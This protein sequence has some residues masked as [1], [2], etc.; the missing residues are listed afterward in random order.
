VFT[1]VEKKVSIAVV[2]VLLLILVAGCGPSPE[3][4]S[5][6][7]ATGKEAGVSDA[8]PRDHRETGATDETAE[9]LAALF[10][11]LDEQFY[12]MLFQPD[13]IEG[14]EE[15]RNYNKKEELLLAVSG[16]VCREFAAP[17]VDEY[18]EEI[19]NKLYII[20]QGAP[21]PLLPDYPMELHKVDEFTYKLVQ[22]AADPMVGD[23]RLTVEFTKIE[24]HWL[25]SSR[26]IE[27]FTP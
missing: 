14:S 22:N 26:W 25:M 17:L 7:N 3:T 10:L 18:Y 24:N 19:D 12:T 1:V 27:G 8:K 15:V 11:S 9:D 20:A 6:T 5:K 4:R 13:L 16:I 2:T 23:Y 21:M